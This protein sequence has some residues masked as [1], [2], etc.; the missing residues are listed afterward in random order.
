MCVAS[1]FRK[2]L[3]CCLSFSKNQLDLNS[4]LTERCL[5]NILSVDLLFQIKI[6]EALKP[7]KEKVDE[8]LAKVK[9]AGKKQD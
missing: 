6:D 8:L 9:T 7:I 5:Q 1:F 3:D 4:L 2:K